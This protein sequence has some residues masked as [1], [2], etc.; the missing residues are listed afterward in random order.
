MFIFYLKADLLFFQTHGR[1]SDKGLVMD[2]IL[3][4]PGQDEFNRG[5][6]MRPVGM[7]MERVFRIT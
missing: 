5:A 3:Q 1:R 2:V 4:P 7:S 6:F